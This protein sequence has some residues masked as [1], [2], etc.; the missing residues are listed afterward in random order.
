MHLNKAMADLN[1]EVLKF[2][3]I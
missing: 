3:V 2:G 1:M